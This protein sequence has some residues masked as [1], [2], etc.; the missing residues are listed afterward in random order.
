MP[1]QVTLDWT[2]NPQLQQV[3][4]WE[5][6]I[7][8]D[9]EVVLTFTVHVHPLCQANQQTFTFTNTAQARTPGGPESG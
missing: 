6:S 9:A 2:G 3:V 8:P 5:G 4:K 1:L 7:L